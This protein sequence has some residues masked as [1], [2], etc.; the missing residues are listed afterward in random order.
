MGKSLMKVHAKIKKQKIEREVLKMAEK[1]L[2]PEIEGGM[3]AVFLLALKKE[4]WGQKRALRL[5]DEV[6]RLEDAILDGEITWKDALEQV[7]DE[8]EIELDFRNVELS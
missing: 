6:Q 3:K 7:K 1:I 5:L 8:Y 4:G 2:V